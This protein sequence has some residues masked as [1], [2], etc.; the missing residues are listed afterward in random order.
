LRSATVDPAA[1]ERWMRE[2]VRESTASSAVEK[3]E[4]H[5]RERDK[6]II[7]TRM[8]VSTSGNLLSAVLPGSRLHRQELPHRRRLVR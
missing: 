6:Q 3:H 2:H 4:N 7:T 5:E 1:A 8:S